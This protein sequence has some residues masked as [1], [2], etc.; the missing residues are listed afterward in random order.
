MKSEERNEVLVFLGGTCN[1]SS[2]RNELIPHL[3]RLGIKYFKWCQ[4]YAKKDLTRT[5]VSYNAGPSCTIQRYK[6]WG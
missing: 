5:L 2:W 1:G 6:N 3:D 4:D